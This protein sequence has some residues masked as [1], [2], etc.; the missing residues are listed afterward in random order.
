MMVLKSS[1]T[2]LALRAKPK[3]ELSPMNVS[4][5]EPQLKVQDAKNGKIPEVPS[6]AGSRK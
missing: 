2:I 1:R 3:A 5:T 4:A 6:A